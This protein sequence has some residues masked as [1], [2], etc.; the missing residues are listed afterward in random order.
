MKLEPRDIVVES[1]Q[2]TLACL[3]EAMQESDLN[4]VL[5]LE[6][7]CFSAPW[8]LR[9]FREELEHP[10]AVV[11]VL[12]LRNADDAFEKRDRQRLGELPA[13]GL[14]DRPPVVGY[15]DYWLVHEEIHLLSLAVHPALR[16]RG[17]G[18][19]MVKRVLEATRFVAGRRV[20]LEVR[21]SNQNAQK[22]YKK[23]R[24]AVTGVR[25]GYY[26]ETGEDALVMTRV[27]DGAAQ[28]DSSFGFDA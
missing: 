28:H 18:E 6:R 15:M 24:F 13:G 1:A 27:V 23:M 8:S 14:R 4:Q 22:L 2:E 3:I 11:E 16:R 10:W 9:M 17:L 5:R 19:T 21:R 26:K 7:A 12:R 25:E 20:V